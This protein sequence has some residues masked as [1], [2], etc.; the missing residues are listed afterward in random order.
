MTLTIDPTVSRNHLAECHALDAHL[1]AWAEAQG[2]D[3]RQFTILIAADA[4][5]RAEYPDAF[6]QLLLAPAAA[7]DPEQPLTS[8]NASL[9]EW[10]LSPAVCYHAYLE[11]SGCTLRRG[12]AVTARGHCFRREAPDDLALGCRQI[13]FQMR[14]LI[15]LGAPDWIED[16]L[17]QIQPEVTALADSFRWPV[18]WRPACDPFFL[19]RSRGKAHLQRLKGTK[20]E[21]CRP[22][23]LAL[24]SINR[25]ADFFGTRFDIR[26]GNGEPAHTACV[27]FG[28]DRWAATLNEENDAHERA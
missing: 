4:L 24:A 10:F 23:G 21:L 3:E 19:P 11:F 2:A 6:P 8:A 5:R 17:R 22:D 28:L 25:H 7:A 18:E 12:I 20:I 1:R 14:E 16:R 26:L 15:L 27:A 9:I 13:E